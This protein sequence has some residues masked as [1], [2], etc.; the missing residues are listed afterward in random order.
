MEIEKRELYRGIA[1][2]AYVIARA[3]KGLSVLRKVADACNG[4][5]ENEA[6]ILDRFKKDLKTL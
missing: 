1:E 4:F 5:S 6:L 2:M 3:D